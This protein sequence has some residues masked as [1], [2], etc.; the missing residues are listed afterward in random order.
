MRFVR[1]K[2]SRSRN[3]KWCSGTAAVLSPYDPESNNSSFARK[4]QKDKTTLVLD[5]FETERAFKC[6][7][8]LTCHIS[9]KRA[10]AKRTNT[11]QHLLRCPFYAVLTPGATLR[12]QNAHVRMVKNQIRLE[13]TKWG[14]LAAAEC[15][16]FEVKTSNDV[17][18]VEYELK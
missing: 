3:M 13:I 5:G 11:I 15:P 8:P 4:A 14:V 9:L 6:K 7:M 12:L 2:W 1:S 16:D 10:M 18:A 17:S